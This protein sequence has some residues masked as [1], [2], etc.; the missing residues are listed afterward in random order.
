MEAH[1]DVKRVVGGLNSLLK[2]SVVDDVEVLGRVLEIGV[3]GISELSIIELLVLSWLLGL[4]NWED[5]LWSVDIGTE[6]EVVD[7]SDVTLI[8]VLSEEELELWLR[9]WNELEGL[10]NS[11]E[12]LGGDVAALGPVVILELWL[13][14]DSLIHNLCSND[15]QEGEE[16]SLFFVGEVGGRL[17]V[18]NNRNWVNRIGEDGVNVIAE[19]GVAD[20]ATL[21]S[22]LAE[23]L[24]N[25]GFGE[26]EVE[27]TQ[28]CSELYYLI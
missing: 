10:E 3:T 28:A 18:L 11:S 16:L 4:V 26:A 25:F 14:Q 17:G 22:V 24:L 7:L 15:G 21:L 27:G 1:L 19:S 6:F 23:E 5:I 2:E 20:E 8:E 9:E 13:D 12:L